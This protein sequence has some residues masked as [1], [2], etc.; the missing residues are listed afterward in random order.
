MRISYW[1][2]SVAQNGSVPYSAFLDSLRDAGYEL[3]K[4][5]MTG[6]AAVIW[7]VLWHGRMSAN[8]SVWKTYRHSRRPVIVL[9]VGCFKRGT[10]WKVGL[11]GI[12]RDAYFGDMGN[13]SDR[14]AVLGLELKPWRKDG[15]Y[16]LICGQ[17]DRSQQWENQPPVSRW[18]MDTIDTLQQHSKRDIVLRPHP[19]CRMP[20]IELQYRGVYRQ[21]PKLV[22]G[23]YD[24]FDLTFERAHAVV[25]WS[26]GPGVHAVLNGVPAFVGPNSLAY[27]VANHH[28]QHIEY[29]G[30]ADRTQWLNDLAWTEYSVE[31]IASGLPLSRLRQTL[32]TEIINAMI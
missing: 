5:S 32:N 4:E 23:T 26:S 13:S 19:R 24:D 15:E 29:P 10:T 8:Q 14:S 7:S 9:E 1:P 25:N 18:L 27:D 11:N 17:H 3:V 28:L 16:I 12:N 22:T 30:H 6:D 2:N 20:A 21:E 31:E